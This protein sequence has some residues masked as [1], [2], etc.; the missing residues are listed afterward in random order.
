[1]NP[2]CEQGVVDL[3]ESAVNSKLEN[4]EVEFHGGNEKGEGFLS[5][6]TFI[7]L[8]N[9]KTGED[10]NLIIKMARS[11]NETGYSKDF[12][13]FS[14]RSEINCYTKVFPAFLKFQKLYPEVRTFDNYPKCYATCLEKGFE[15]FALQNLK[16]QGYELHPKSK[17]INQNLYEQIFK[18]YG[19]F[20]ALSF[21]LKHHQPEEFSRLTKNLTNNWLKFNESDYAN[22]IITYFLGKIR[23]YLEEDG[24][25][26]IIEKLEKYRTNFVNIFNESVS[27]SVSNG[28]LLHG[29]CWSNN[30]ML[31]FDVRK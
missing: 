21:A 26:K 9:K 24:E 22:N 20:H 12:M 30:L 16:T 27:C 3:L 28:L 4:F 15:K 1:M 23:E 10:Y 13:T 8:K 19:E 11:N 7:S 5:E 2:V 29:D 6:M 25:D 14:F 18:M 17:M 31:K